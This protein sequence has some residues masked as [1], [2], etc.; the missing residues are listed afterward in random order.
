[1]STRTAT[2]STATPRGSRT[3]RLIGSRCHGLWVSWGHRI[4]PRLTPWNGEQGSASRR[5]KSGSLPS[6]PTRLSSTHH[7]ACHHTAGSHGSWSPGRHLPPTTPPPHCGLAP[8]MASQKEPAPDKYDQGKVV[9]VL[10]MDSKRLMT[11]WLEVEVRTLHARFLCSSLYLMR[12]PKYIL[13]GKR[14]SI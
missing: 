6:L 4:G 9:S 14:S 10:I 3:R 12:Q 11:K 5:R 1:M 7:W 8:R 13:N 2:P